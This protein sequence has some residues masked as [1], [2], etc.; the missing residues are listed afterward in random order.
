MIT[1]LAAFGATSIATI[2]PVS[3]FLAAQARLRGEVEI[4]AHY[5]ASQVAEEARQNP[6][7]WNA[8][9]DSS[10]GEPLDNLEIGRPL[11]AATAS[12]FDERLLGRRVGGLRP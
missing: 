7:F 9:A 5:Y 11:H 2:M 3:C 10:T 8:L 4:S 1:L 12:G 6:A